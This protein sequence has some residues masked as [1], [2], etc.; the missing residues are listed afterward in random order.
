MAALA[1]GGLVLAGFAILLA[2]E[3][4]QDRRIARQY[5]ST[6]RHQKVEVRP[7]VF[8]CQACGK[9]GLDAAVGA[10]P[11]CGSRFLP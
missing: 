8:E 3:L 7:G 6:L 10:C 4:S 9:V 11:V 5:D 2:V 1:V